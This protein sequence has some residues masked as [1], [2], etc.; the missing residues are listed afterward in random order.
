MKE[1]V[2]DLLMY[3]FENFLEDEQ[4]F[5]P[6]S[7]R[8]SLQ[9]SLMEAGFAPDEINKAFDWLEAL[10]VSTPQGRQESGQSPASRIYAPQEQDRL[11]VECRGFLLQL[12]EIGILSAQ[13]RELVIDR[14]MDLE[15]EELDLERLKWVVLLVLFAQPGEEDAYAWMEDLVFENSVGYLH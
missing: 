14:V 4:A 13:S 11:D 7:D 6:A 3:L 9:L 5:L 10:A 12:E 15:D 1:N 2:L 8:E